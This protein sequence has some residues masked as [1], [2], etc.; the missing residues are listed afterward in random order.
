LT[1]FL[2]GMDTILANYPPYVP[3]INKK[4]TIFYGKPIY[5]DEMIQQ[6][7]LD[8]KKPVIL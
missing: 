6:L 7:K 3:Q 4:T 5:F 2:K 8:K 1:T